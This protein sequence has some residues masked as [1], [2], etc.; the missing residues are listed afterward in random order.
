LL[1]DGLDIVIHENV[2]L[3]GGTKG[4]TAK[5]LENSGMNVKST[6]QSGVAT[7]QYE[8]ES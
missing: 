8:R 3:R 4:T 2:A 5:M 1:L 6:L 7:R